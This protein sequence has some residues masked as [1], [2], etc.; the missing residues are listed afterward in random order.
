MPNV[1]VRV[2][3]NVEIQMNQE[4]FFCLMGIDC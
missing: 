2:N 3:D 1:L 4:E